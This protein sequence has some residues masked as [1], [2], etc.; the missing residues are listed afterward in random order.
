MP[1]HLDDAAVRRLLRLEDLLAGM[2]RAL[3]DLSAGRVVQPLRLVMDLP[4]G[5]DFLMVKPALTADALITK[6]ITLRQANAARGLPSMLAT[7]VLMD[8]ATGETL[9]V[10]DATWLTELRTAAVSAVAAEALTPPGPKVV[11]LLG[12]GALARSHALALRA[13][14]PVSEVRVWSRDPANVARCAKD[15]GGIGCAS[16]EQA[17]RGADIVCTVT[18]ASEPV[19]AGAWLKPGAFVAAVGAPRP[20]WRELDDAAMRN[21]LVAD[22]REAAEKESGD[23]ILSGAR[24][25][26]EIGEILAG[27]KPPPAKGATVIFKALG[28]AVEDAVAARLVYDAA[29]REA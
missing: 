19:L 20:A 22:S 7:L 5:Q 25:S 9:A 27:T 26:A 11:A 24:V 14:R 13:V 28:Q 8:P 29:L 23:V 6:L 16:A 17:V 12:S 18:S 15:I 4:G 10:M 1:L 21:V 2:R 3:M